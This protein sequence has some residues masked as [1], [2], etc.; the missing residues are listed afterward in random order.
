MAL[1]QSQSPPGFES[2]KDPIFDS[3]KNSGNGSGDLD[4]EGR[5]RRRSSVGKYGARIGPV[6]P[7]LRGTDYA[8]SDSEADILAGQIEA[9]SNNT[10]QYRTCS[11]QKVCN[12]TPFVAQYNQVVVS[13]SCVLDWRTLL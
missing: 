2:N 5:G 11:W 9:E 6:L 10:I 3:E 12:Y 13:N 7:H 8:S 4:V 1:N